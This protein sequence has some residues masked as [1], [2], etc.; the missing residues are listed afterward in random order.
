MQRINSET[1]VDCHFIYCDFHF[2]LVPPLTIPFIT[3]PCI[4]VTVR[5]QLRSLVFITP[6]TKFCV[7]ANILRYFLPWCP[8]ERHSWI[9]QGN[10]QKV[11]AF[12]EVQGK[13][14]RN[15]LIKCGLFESNIREIRGI[16]SGEIHKHEFWSFVKV[17]TAFSITRC[18]TSN[19][20]SNVSV[21]ISKTIVREWMKLCK[22]SFAIVDL[23]RWVFIASR[24]LAKKDSRGTRSRRAP[25]IY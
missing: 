24:P 9:Y 8:E 3:T 2:T 25:E 19:A 13:A 7:A 4:A 15:K 23:E 1:T 5:P 10:N 20:Q 21:L 16:L 17:N 14:L 11:L 12:E 6:K 18:R 22:S